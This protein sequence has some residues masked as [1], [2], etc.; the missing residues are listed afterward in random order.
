MIHIIAPIGA[1]FLKQR[2]AQKKNVGPSVGS[3]KRPRV[4]STTGDI[5]AEESLV[6]P[7]AVIADD[8]DDG[9]HAD[10]VAVEPTVPPPLSLCAMME[11]F[12]TTQAAHGQLLDELI[13]EVAALRVDFLE[14]RSAFPPP[15]PSNS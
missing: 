9:V 10:S 12:M 15:P 3:S 6:D 2:S 8:S 4:Q 14:Y 5:H 13:A 11:T 7:T 1:T